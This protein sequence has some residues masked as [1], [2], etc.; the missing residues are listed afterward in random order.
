M[1]KISE[2]IYKIYRGLDLSDNLGDVAECADELGELLE[3]IEE[4]RKNPA[5]L[6][7]F[8]EDAIVNGY[9]SDGYYYCSCSQ[10]W[11]HPDYMKQCDTCYEDSDEEE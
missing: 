8:D 5:L 11:L 1:N 4:A 10:E 6:E 9:L 7:D 3:L 2:K